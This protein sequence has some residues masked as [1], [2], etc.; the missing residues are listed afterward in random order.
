[1]RT[2]YSTKQIKLFLF[3]IFLFTFGSASYGQ[4]T[5]SVFR[6]YNGDGTKQ[7]GEPGKDRIEVYAYSNTALPGK[8]ALVAQTTTD[9]NGNYTINSP[10]YPVRLEFIIPNGFCNM[11][12]D[13]DYPSANLTAGINTSEVQVANDGEVH[14]FG[15]VYPPDF[16]TEDNPR[17]FL[18]RYTS[19]NG[20]LPGSTANTP[21]MISFH[22]KDKGVAPNSGR[23][24]GTDDNVPFDTVALYSQLGTVH[25]VAYSR[26]AKKVFTSAFLKRHAGLGPLG[27]GGIYWLDPEPPYDLNANLNFMDFDDLGIPTSDE[28]SPY[29]DNPPGSSALTVTFSPVIGTNVERGLPSDR[30]QPSHDR[31]AWT[32]I[33]KLSFGDL[34]IS[35][36]GQYLYVVNLYDRKLYEIDLTDPFNPVAPT[37]ANAA[38]KIHGYQIPDPCNAPENG[39]YR[40]FALKIARG[41]VYVG[42]TC[43][44]QDAIGNTVANSNNDVTSS[45]FEFDMS[46]HTF[47]PAPILSYDYGYRDNINPWNAWTNNWVGDWEKGYPLLSDI[48]FDNNGNVLLGIKDLRGD[49]LGHA[50]YSIDPNST[51]LSSMAT[52]GELLNAVRDATSPSCSYNIQLD[53]EFYNDNLIHPESSQGA[54]AVHHTSDFDGAMSTFLD[55][56]PGHVWAG[57]VMLYNNQDGSQVF[58]R[59]YEVFYSSNNGMF[60][61]ANGLGDLE[62]MEVIPPIEIGNIVWLDKDKD[63]IQDSDE[64]GIEGVIVELVQ[65]GNVVSTT[66]TDNLGTYY[67]N[68]TNTNNGEGPEPNT[69]YTL[70]ISTTQFL[71]GVGSGPLAL[72]SLTLTNEVGNGENDWSDN[73]ASDVAGV[74]QFDIT[75]GDPGQNNHSYD[76][77]FY[78]KAEIGNYVWE[79][80]DANG[81]QDDGDTGI[82]GIEVKLYEGNG[83]YVTSMLTTN[84]PNTG[85]PGYYLFSNLEPG[86]YYVCFTKGIYGFSPKDQG[87]DDLD[88][89]ADETTGCAEVTT[90]D[91]GES[92]MSWDAG[93]FQL[94]SLGDYVWMDKDEDGIQDI[95]ENPLKNVVVNLYEDN[96]ADGTPDGPAIAQTQTDNN[97]FYEF[98]D[99]RPGN[100]IV[101]FERPAGYK[102]VPQDQGGDDAKDS[103]YDPNTLLTG[104]INLESGEND[105][106]IDAGFKVRFDLALKKYKP[107]T[108]AKQGENITFD[109]EIYNQS[110]IGADVQDVEITDYINLAA[111][112]FDPALNP[113]WT[114]VGNK[115]KYIYN[116]PLAAQ[117][118]DIVQITLTVKYGATETDLKNEAEISGFKDMDGELQTEEKDSYPDDDPDNDN[119]VECGSAD[120]DYIDGNV[121][122]NPGDD[123]DDN[124]VACVDIFDLALKKV[125]TSTGPYK[126]GDPVTFTYTIYNQGNM[127]ATNIEVT[128]YVPSG[129]EY[130]PAL[131]GSWTQAATTTPKTTIT[132]TLNPGESTTVTLV[133]IV[134]YTADQVDG[135][136]N[137]AEISKGE[138]TNGNDWSNYD[139]DGILDDT[140]DN[141][142]GGK[143]DTPS[144]NSVDGDGTGAPGDTDP[145]TD[146]DDADPARVKIYDLA[147]RKVVMTPEPYQYY[148]D[149]TFEITVFN[150]GN[151]AMT[152]IEVSDYIPEGYTFDSGM[153]AGWNGAAPTVSTVIAGPLVPGDSAKVQ[154]VLKLV[155][156]GGGETKWDNYA[157]ITGMSDSAG[158]PADS[159]DA[160]STPDTDAG[161]ERAVKPEDPD[162]DNIDGH[163]IPDMTDEDDHDPAGIHVL[164]LALNKTTTAQPPFQY[165][166]I[167]DFTFTIYNQGNEI[168]HDIKVMDYVPSGFIYLPHIN[169]DWTQA[170]TDLPETTVP[171]SLAPGESTTVTIKLQ[172]QYTPEVGGYV[173]KAEITGAKDEDNND[174]VDIDST[175]DDD[176]DNDI[177]GTPLTP[178][179]DNVS[180]D[181]KDGDGD[182]VTDEDD[183]DPWTVE[184]ASIGNYVWYDDNDNGIQD[185]GMPSSVGVENITVILQDCNGVELLRTTTDENGHYDFS[186]LIPGDYLVVF[187]DLPNNS[188]WAKQNIGNDALD[189]DPDENGIATCTNLEA[190]EDD[191]TWDAGILRLSSLGDYV[192]LDEDADGIQDVEESAISGVVV[193]LYD[194]QG[195]VLETTTT[196]EQGYYLFDSL[197]PGTYV[198]QFENPGGLDYSPVGQGGDPEKDSDADPANGGKTSD[199]VLGANEDRRDIDA[200][201]TCTLSVEVSP[202]VIICEGETVDLTA[203]ITG[204]QEPMTIIWTTGETT[205][206]ISVTPS[207]TTVYGVTVTDKYGCE[208]SGEV[209]VTVEP[210]AKIGDY[211]WLDLDRDGIQDF[212]IQDPDLDEPGINGVTVNL[213]KADDPNTIFM[214]QLTHVN[215]DT[216]GYYEFEVCSGDY[217]VEFIAPTGEGYIFTQQDQGTDDAL[218]SDA[219]ET[220]GRTIATHLDPAEVDHTWDA[221]F[222]K[223]ASLGDFVWHDIDAD[224]IQDPGEEGIDGV[225]VTLHRADGSVVGTTTTANGGLYEF[226]DLLPD[227]YY[228][229]FDYSATIYTQ[230]SP[231]NQGANDELDSDVDPVGGCTEITTIVSGENDITWDMGL[232]TLASLGDYVWY[233]KDGDGCQD[234]DEVGIEGVTVRLYEDNDANGIPD[235]P[236]LANTQTDGTGFYQFT[237]LAA[238]TYVVKFDKPNVDYKVSPKNHNGADGCDDASDSDGDDIFGYSDPIPLADN[239]HDPTID[240]GY[241]ESA[242][243]GDFVW[244]DRDG[245]G[246]QDPGEEGVSGVTV[247]LYKDTDGDGIP[248]SPVDTK[249][250]NTGGDAGSYVFEDV[251][252]GVYKICFDTDGDYDGFTKSNEGGDDAVDSDP[253]QQTGCTE[254]IVVESGDDDMTWDAGLI[255]YAQLGDYVWVDENADGYQDPTESPIEGVMVILEDGQ[256]NKLDTTYTDADGLYLFDELLPGD[257]VVHFEKPVGYEPTDKDAVAS[258]TKDSDADP[259]SGDSHLVTLEAGDS[260]MTID[261]GFYQPASLGDYVWEDKDADGIQ[262]PDEDGINGIVVTL[263]DENG[264]PVANTTTGV[265][266]NTGDDGFYEFDDLKPGTY[267]VCFDK[268]SWD[269]FSPKDEGADNQ[270]DSDVDPQGGCTELTVLESGE[271]D[272]SWD[273]GLYDYASLG[274]YVWL[275]EDA[276]GVQ[277]ASE[278]GINDME[279]KLYADTD[280]DCN[281][282]GAPIATTTTVSHLGNDGYYIFENLE[283]GDYVVFFSPNTTYDRTDSNIGNDAE[284]SDANEVTGLS[285]CINLES[286]EHD[287]TI[288]AGY[289]YASGLGDYTWFDEDGDGVQDEIE[290]CIDSIKIVLYKVNEIAPGVLDTVKVDST[291]SHSVLSGQDTVKC[292]FYEFTRLKPGDYFLIFENPD[293]M[294][295][296]N[297]PQD[298]LYDDA[299][300]SD[301]DKEGFTATVT[302]DP[303]EYDPTIDA[304]F[305]KGDCIEGIVWKDRPE[306]YYE[307]AANGDTIFTI[308]DVYDSLDIPLEGIGVKLYSDP[309]EFDPNDD[310]LYKTA[311]TNSEGIYRF[312]NI[313]IGTYYL[314]LDLPDSL[315]TVNNDVGGDDTQDNDFY[316]S[317][318]TGEYRSQTFAM[319]A[320]NDEAC[321]TD[322]DGGTKKK[323]Q[324]QPLDMLAY[325]VSYNKVEKLVDIVWNTMNEINADYY[326]VERKEEGADRYIEISEVEAKGLRTLN[327][328]GLKDPNVEGGNRYYYKLTGYDKD[329]RENGV[330]IDNVLIPAD[331]FTVQAYPNPVNERLYV[332]VSGNRGKEST[333]QIIDGIGRKAVKTISLN[334]GSNYEKVAIDMSQLPQGQYYIKVISGDQV[335][336]KKV[337][338]VN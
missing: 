16:A 167:I 185:D 24:S 64:E 295:Y 293:T 318:E 179:D 313:E 229:C 183:E 95:D 327:S 237:E 298:E 300:D 209:T 67:F 311:V 214:T 125:E 76:F 20:L 163:Y 59:G 269:K 169:T 324:T 248:D 132:T 139:W 234:A 51:G 102:T 241:Y 267:Y 115:A 135:W 285:D 244:F 137:V 146:E 155:Q 61:K 288:D 92:D 33:G 73:D 194:D 180:D 266:P 100:Y 240:Q 193:K 331:K 117:T 104:T 148:D 116:G 128:D 111:Y 200:G 160:D 170:L 10:V 251:D 131:N 312:D 147:L 226:T 62:T 28:A 30:T 72:K 157:E 15:I 210:K 40:P 322:I 332:V 136:T 77:G 6:D 238:G 42:V 88:S 224:G 56:V 46:T 273:A 256:G 109:I 7:A 334:K 270:K 168:A 290:K 243:L 309:N 108:P 130:D 176:P 80:M 114:L 19:G 105:P 5:G 245:D 87:N 3:V 82:N 294:E 208:D 198:V 204:G 319:E 120:D 91:P 201:F 71:N 314:V 96:D 159:W 330:Y 279:V 260:D 177:G 154:I 191:P 258:D 211:V 9:A 280:G 26:Q 253:D 220:T 31:A 212:Y 11:A 302:L 45:V 129:F 246:V 25:G 272:P 103:D 284:D 97:G 1:M 292:G 162:D 303:G 99:L 215:A 283:P 235:G 158:T 151:E 63:G 172:F 94:A 325:E 89:D 307:L 13:Q 228:L 93:L 70:R 205:E 152:N 119:D 121:K 47:D 4:I 164:D 48:D 142:A 286:G 287:P 254:I 184:V 239:Q 236:E 143:A 60:G 122:E 263:H 299:K 216:S 37:A 32:Q 17:V 232:Y 189:S 86:D 306:G 265:N 74:V 123:E 301:I 66:T 247:T 68:F 206:I 174:F 69:N 126:F 52:V 57:G 124:D 221:G 29:T 192:W 81:I 336:I 83:T 225:T 203:T 233:D 289:F 173:N 186:N 297:S 197:R 190:G 268:G 333:I 153:N 84:D 35:E 41:K 43:S 23:G 161:H 22:Y 264:D 281:P 133:L 118:S 107:T 218:D 217:F 138:D 166:Q 90:L 274:D 145:A 36:D 259:V 150:Q 50:N 98:T 171:G 181:G 278:S 296:L 140:P 213:Y 317:E 178:E 38:Q 21:A 230:V 291:Y 106:T 323:G 75:T 44:G 199:I 250:T 207:V 255:K 315:Q 18:P 113:G 78:P 326:V 275:D 2:Y 231:Q 262:D 329:G 305:Y 149:L 271:N 320:D 53:P 85:K 134:Q 54:L 39:E 187:E 252:P 277:D 282:D 276:D 222:Y 223:T 175:P 337:V 202:D 34:E 55:P 316:L 242:R 304:G 182:G 112:D 65:N 14:N 101:G 49:Q 335:E 261:A 310:V 8:D 141:D 165:D 195:N 249:V 227:D 156:T 110:E 144:D 188:I 58:G 338:H 27:G 127:A 321:K 79:D 257:Y 308:V 12:S 328:Y 196:D 219:D